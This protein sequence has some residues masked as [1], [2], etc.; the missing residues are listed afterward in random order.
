MSDENDVR[1]NVAALK[2]AP[3][4]K[5]MTHLAVGGLCRQAFEHYETGVAGL[6]IEDATSDGE[7]TLFDVDTAS[8]SW[9]RASIGSMRAA[10]R[11]GKKPNSTPMPAEKTNDSTLITGSNR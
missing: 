2:S 3:A 1:D 11:A 4:L 10:R 9:R 6:S 7:K 8:H 5:V